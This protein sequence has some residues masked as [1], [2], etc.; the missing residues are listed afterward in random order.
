MRTYTAPVIT[1][2]H[3]ILYSSEADAVRVFLRDTLELSGIDGG[4]GWTIFALPPA[5]VAVHPTEEGSRHE[6]YLMCDDI[7]ATVAQLNAKGVT[8][9]AV[10][11]AGWGRRIAVTLP[12]GSQLAIYE[13]RHPTAH[14]R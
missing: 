5:E 14:P 3:A 13:P 8:T 6:L 2:A 7:D 11:D 10:V 9:S 4:G 1:G 12:D